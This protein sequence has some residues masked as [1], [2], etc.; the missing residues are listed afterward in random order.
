[1][2]KHGVIPEK[3]PSPGPVI[4]EALIE[5]KRLAYENRLEGKNLD[6][7]DELEDEEDDDFLNQYKTQRLSELSTISKT[8]IYNQVYPLQKPDYSREV[9]EVSHKSFVLVL[10][11]S[12]LGTN[13]ES[14][15]LT[16]LW[17]EL[18]AKFGDVKFC[19]IRAN[20]CIEGYPERNTP[21]V[22]VYK[23]GDIKRQIV[24]LNDLNG[25]HCGVEDIEKMLVDVGAVKQ[26]DVRVQKRTEENDVKE[27]RSIRNR[28]RARE[29][30]GD[31]DWD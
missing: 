17:H 8:S 5:A 2:R 21:T 3:P 28:N 11:T 15:L 14:A 27:S 9:T 20:L 23:D 12:S 19:Q 31:S 7:L 18:A 1:M 16:G 6:E 24:T 4:E 10:L 25:T 22:L 13:T 26:N 30:D 29:E